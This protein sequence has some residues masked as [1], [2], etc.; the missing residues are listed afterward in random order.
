M[1]TIMSIIT[2]LH[3]NY[4]QMLKKFK[5]LLILLEFTPPHI[6]VFTYNIVNNFQNYKILI[7]NILLHK[8]QL[9]GHPKFK[10]KTAFIYQTINAIFF[11]SAK[12]S[13]E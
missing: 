8:K 6:Y 13:I 7:L 4:L 2:F 1:L 12:Q 10:S 11:S 5:F 3:L 9:R